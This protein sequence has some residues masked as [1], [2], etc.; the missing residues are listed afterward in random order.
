MNHHSA[1]N[2]VQVCAGLVAAPLA[3]L[4][5]VQLGQILPYLDCANRTHNTAVCVVG[6]TV[7]ALSAGVLL[8]RRGG[9]AFPDDGQ[10]RRFVGLVAGLTAMAI[11]FALA[12]QLLAAFTLN[13]CE[14]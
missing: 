10:P 2:A 1:L 14:R 13:A 4:V 6:A 5:S 9:G 12:L 11:S 3:W 8:W 7:V